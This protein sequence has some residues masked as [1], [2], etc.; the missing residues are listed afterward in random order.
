MGKAKKLPSGNYRVREYDYTDENKVKH[1]KSFTSETKAMAELMAKEYKAGKIKKKKKS[2]PLKLKQAY[3]KYI[4]LK[5]PVLSPSTIREYEK[6]QKTYLQ[7]LMTKDIEDITQE[8]VQ[9]AI[10]A[11]VLKGIAPKT[12]RNIH[13]LLS[14][15]MKQ[16]RPNFALNTTLPKKVKTEISIPTKEEVKSILDYVKNTDMEI[17]LL[18]CSGLGLRRSELCALRW[19]DINFKE[20]TL[21]IEKALV[22]NKNK[23]WV[24]KTPKT[25]A[26]YR[27]LSI[28]DYIF[29]VLKYNKNQNEYITDLRPHTI[30]F[31]YKKILKEL[32]LPDYRLHDLRHYV[33]SIMLALKIPDKYAMEIM[34]HETEHMLNKVYQHTMQKEMKKYTSK[35][36]EFFN[37]NQ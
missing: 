2:E 27:T 37:G 22:Q 12:V 23:E 21:R 11:E 32:N 7:N 9:N 19:E 36:N 33:A 16:F 5:E 34:G 29:K 20:Q 3:E 30:Y 6:Q 17:P 1:Y 8:D 35:M 24:I 31:R 14:S 25:T 26:G 28:P 15:V 18:L 4:A 13:G 10:N